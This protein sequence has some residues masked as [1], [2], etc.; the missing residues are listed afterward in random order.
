[1]NKIH[2]S[3]ALFVTC[4]VFLANTGA[5]MANTQSSGVLSS[6]VPEAV[7][8]LR[9]IAEIDYANQGS[10]KNLCKNKQIVD[11]MKKNKMTCKS[12]TDTYV[13]FSKSN[14]K[15][16]ICVDHTGFSGVVSKKPK[17]KCATDT[18]EVPSRRLSIQEK[19]SIPVLKRHEWS[20]DLNH[21]YYQQM[22]W[23]MRGETY[24]WKHDIKNGSYL[25]LCKDKSLGKGYMSMMK[26]DGLRDIECG[27]SPSWFYIKAT[28]PNRWSFCLNRKDGENNDS[29][30]VMENCSGVV[31]GTFTN[32]VKVN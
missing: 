14:T 29:K 7:H 6:S 19:L 8:L 23:E 13:L 18:A 5:A 28:M 11:G 31:K 27:D 32:L 4:C 12:T 22:F 20:A 30:E 17:G 2:F 21:K 26:K 9:V 16:I 1:M 15:K 24:S 3:A 25:G 10:F